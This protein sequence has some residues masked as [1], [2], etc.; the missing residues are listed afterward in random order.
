MG[1]DGGAFRKLMACWAGVEMS[2]F[3]PI[4]V[5]WRRRSE[6]ACAA[7]RSVG[8]KVVYGVWV[9]RCWGELVWDR[10]W[11]GFGEDEVLLWRFS[12]FLGSLDVAFRVT[13]KVVI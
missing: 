11:R 13:G 12:F 2:A 1:D 7:D 4:D 3:S 10:D 8:E 5:G 6:K 9:H